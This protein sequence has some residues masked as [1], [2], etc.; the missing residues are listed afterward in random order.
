MLKALDDLQYR[1]A[2]PVQAAVIEPVLAGRDLVVRAKTGTGKTAAFAIP[3][4]ERIAGGMRR[5]CVLVLTPTRE[6]ALQVA[7]ECAGVARYKDV[8]VGALYGGVPI[9]PQVHALEEGVEIVVGTPGRVL[10]HL[11]RGTL[12]LGSVRTAVL[13]EADEM[14]SMGFLEDVT[15][16]LDH[17]SDNPQVLLLSATVD[18]RLAQV[19]RKYLHD[20]EHVLLST[21]TDKVEGI[22]HVLYETSPDVH[23]ARS[24]LAVI[25]KEDPASALIFV[26]TREDATTVATFLH[27]QGLDA[28]AISGSLPQNQRERVLARL[29]RGELQFLVATDVAARGIDVSGLSHVIQYALPEDPAVYLHRSG[30]TGRLGRSGVAVALAG[31]PDLA[32]RTV[33]ERRYDIAFDVRP[34]PTEEEA[35]TLRLQRQA[36]QLGEASEVTAFEGYLGTVRALRDRPDGDRL[37]AVALRAFFLWDRT[38][39]A[40]GAEAETAGAPEGQADVPSAP[41]SETRGQRRHR[42]PRRGRRSR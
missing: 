13:D 26:N 38:R 6:L 30:R 21:D 39:R 14:L 35:A 25:E 2:T 36:R 16:I 27:R 24:L 7:E 20:P 4:V 23:R 34:V 33:L 15:A 19:V 29:K 37:L 8:R 28:E 22:R 9:G 5:P 42:H 31:G 12:E 40:R 3:L 11:R 17:L 18:P 32:T 1:V 41:T 10:D